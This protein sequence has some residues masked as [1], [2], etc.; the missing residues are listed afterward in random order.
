MV[1]HM[2]DF[3]NEISTEDENRAIRLF[4]H[5]EFRKFQK[6]RHGRRP[7]SLLQ[8]EENEEKEENEENEEQ[9]ENSEEHEDEDEDDDADEEV[10]IDHAEDVA[11]S[12][13]MEG[14]PALV[15]ED[16]VLEDGTEDDKGSRRRRRR[17]SRRWIG[18]DLADAANFRRYHRKGGRGCRGVHGKYHRVHGLC[19]YA[20]EFASTGYDYEVVPVAVSISLGPASTRRSHLK[21]ACVLCGLAGLRFCRGHD[22]EN[23]LGGDRLGRI[24]DL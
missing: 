7:V 19:G 8:D 6:D 23:L 12:K 5:V 4:D 1:G 22:Q 21:T 2:R 18:G 15:E 14:V 13:D 20:I 16:N 9:Q 11:G 17:R 24:R 3:A 10:A